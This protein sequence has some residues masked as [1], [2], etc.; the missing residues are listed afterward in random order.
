MTI[1]KLIDNTEI[2]QSC[3]MKIKT[4]KQLCWMLSL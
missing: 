3:V 4:E 2:E 1:V